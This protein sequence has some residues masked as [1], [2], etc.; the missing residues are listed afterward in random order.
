LSDNKSHSEAG[1]A[2]QS[3][4]NLPQEYRLVPVDDWND[5]GQNK[6]G[7]NRHIDVRELANTAWG[8]RRFIIKVTAVFVV[9][10]IIIALLSPVE[11]KTGATLLPESKKSSS[12]AQGL[13]EEYGPLLGIG[14]GNLNLDQQESI[15]P[16][17]YSEIVNI[18]PFQLEL[19]NKPVTFSIYDTTVTSYT[20]F[21]EVH[22]PSAFNTIK[23]YT[24]GLPAKIKSLFSA[25]PPPEPL[26][27]GFAADSIITLTKG[28]TAIIN[29]MRDRI[30]VELDDENGTVLLNTEMPDP[31]AAAE[32][33]KIGIALLKEY[34]TNYRIQKA[35]EDLEFSREQM[36]KAKQEFENV[37]DK[38]AEFEDQN[39]GQLTAK[40]R[41][42]EQRLQAE[43]DL[44]FNKYNSLAQQVEQ[45]KLRVQEKT[46]VV[47][48]LQP[49]QM[50]VDN[51]KPK[52][53]LIVIISFVIGLMLSIGYIVA[54]ELQASQN[55]DPSHF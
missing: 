38:K 40:A 22:T 20:F 31:N 51:Y 45:A 6:G 27:Q 54:K 9:I 24:L 43:Y 35:S 7:N 32:I 44:T 47:T 33:G 3:G 41:T 46:P 26:P 30:S 29:K 49:I 1:K 50:P 5:I 34:V 4:E 55:S 28:Q 48:V 53:N 18:L 14:G 21:K 52:R 19:L 16:K 11:Y 17:L 10:G 36:L 15:S 42:Q 39:F 25:E 12:S 8:H 13:L 2:D 23:G 37:Q